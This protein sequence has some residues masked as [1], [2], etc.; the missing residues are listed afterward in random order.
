MHVVCAW[1][2]NS[3]PVAAQ[4][5]LQLTDEH[6]RR[7][8]SGSSALQNPVQSLHETP[9]NDPQSVNTARRKTPENTGVCGTLRR[10]AVN[11]NYPARTRTDHGNTSSHLQLG[12]PLPAGAAFS[13][14]VDARGDARAA[15]GR[16][17]EIAGQAGLQGLCEVW[18]DLPDSTR[19]RILRLADEALQPDC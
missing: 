4:H 17:G 11:R 14:A 19:D 10:T 8:V 3:Q 7:A 6:F 12:K 5:Y 1:I 16:V 9:G 2:G 13:G 18:S 15:D